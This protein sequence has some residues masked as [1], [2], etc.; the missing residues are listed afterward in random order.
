MMSFW[1][2]RKHKDAE[3]DTEIQTHL[4]LA[5]QERIERGE[6]PET[7]RVEVLRQFGNVALVKEVT[8]EMW[9]GAALARLVQDLRFGLRMLQKS[10][11]FSVV[12]ILTLA[13]GIGATTA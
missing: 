12:V 3:L 2:S 9:S 6:S 5:I 13:L 1:K 4:E 7:A 8:R 11:G 10:P